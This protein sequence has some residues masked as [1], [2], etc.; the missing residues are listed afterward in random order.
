M[1]D[2]RFDFATFIN[3]LCL[4]PPGAEQ[5]AHTGGGLML[6]LD[7]VTAFFSPRLPLDSVVKTQVRGKL[8]YILGDS[9]WV[10]KFKS[11]EKIE[12]IMLT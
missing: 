7:I 2:I 6:P 12:T 1:R 11:G 9:I 10:L 8:K 3:E 5:S 4:D